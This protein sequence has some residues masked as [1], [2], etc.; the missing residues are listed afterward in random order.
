MYLVPARLST[1]KDMA[2]RVEAI[3]SGAPDPLSRLVRS[4]GGSVRAGSIVPSIARLYGG[5][6]VGSRADIVSRPVEPAPNEP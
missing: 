4:R 2:E 5:R 3:K 6:M 1:P